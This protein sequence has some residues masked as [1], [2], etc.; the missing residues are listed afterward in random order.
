MLASSNSYV[1]RCAEK[2]ICAVINEIVLISTIQ[3]IKCAWWSIQDRSLIILPQTRCAELYC[4]IYIYIYIY[5]CVCVCVC[6]YFTL[7]KICGAANEMKS[8]FILLFIT[9]CQNTDLH[10]GLWR[11]FVSIKNQY[12]YHCF[13]VTETLFRVRISLNCHLSAEEC[14]PFTHWWKLAIFSV[15]SKKN[16]DQSY[17]MQIKNWMYQKLY[18]GKYTFKKVIFL[19]ECINSVVQLELRIKRFF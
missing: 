3:S 9:L 7:N 17:L 6:V 2:Y 10:P 13:L 15:W 4:Y 16:I 18:E 5:V 1:C 19:T 14:R 12:I 8:F 11:M